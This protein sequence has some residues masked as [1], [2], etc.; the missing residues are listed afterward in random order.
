M[1]CLYL[2]SVHKKK[3]KNSQTSALFPISLYKFKTL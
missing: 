2:I 1:I 3:R